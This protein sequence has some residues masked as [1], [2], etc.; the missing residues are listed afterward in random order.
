MEF[1]ATVE[2]LR[3]YTIHGEPYAVLYYSRP[4]HPEVVEQAQLSL[5]ALPADLQVGERIVILSLL[6]VVAEVRRSAAQT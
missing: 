5:D 1:V 2:G 6:S 3:R 4:E